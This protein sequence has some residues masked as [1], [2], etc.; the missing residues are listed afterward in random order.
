MSE[1]AR[2]WWPKPLIR[3]RKSPALPRLPQAGGV[4]S[5]VGQVRGGEGVEAL[6]LQHYA[7]LTLPGME[8]LARQVAGRWALDGLLICTG[9]GDAAGR[10]DRAGGRRART[11]AMPLPRWIS[12]WTI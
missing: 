2:G 3:A 1:L 10:A 5:F 9:W 8:A 12:R 7:P 4:V 6:E 11:G